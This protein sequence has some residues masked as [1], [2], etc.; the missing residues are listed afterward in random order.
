MKEFTTAI[1]QN[2]VPDETL[3]FSIDGHIV[4]AYRPT[5]GQLAMLMA[6]LGRHTE[7]TTKVAGVID[8]F[9]TILDD[10]SYDYVVERLLSRK[11]PL[12]M[13]EV[14]NI[15]SWLIEE[16]SGRP[17]PPPSVSTQSPG[18]GGRN[19]K[20]RTTKS[21]SSRSVPANSAT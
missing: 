9:V 11:D 15:I 4:T 14:Q 1:E 21:T 6:N 13:D 5:D 12:G 20:P 19:S 18:S 7:T 8:F 16:W 2:E 10:D 17:T 3:E